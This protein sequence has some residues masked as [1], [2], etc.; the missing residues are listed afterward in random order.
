MLYLHLSCSIQYNTLKGLYP[1]G[2]LVSNT[3]SI[4]SAPALIV[5]L[6]HAPS[7]RH[8]LRRSRYH[9]LKGL[10][11][12]G[13]TR[14][15]NILLS[16]VSNTRHNTLKGLYPFGLSVSNTRH[17]YR[18]PLL[19]ILLVRIHLLRSRSNALKGLY[20]FGQTRSINSTAPAL[21]VSR[22]FTLYGCHCYIAIIGVK[23]APS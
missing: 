15:I 11:P 21:T 16:L 22:V 2:V 18:I 13:E 10:Y 20:P 14:S 9:V 8:H 19:N 5:G 7:T 6:K 1:F 23:H 3:R 4:S 12:F 17:W